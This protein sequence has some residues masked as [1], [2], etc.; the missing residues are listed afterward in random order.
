[1]DALD[2]LIE[3]GSIEPQL[4]MKI[5]RHFDKSITQILHYKA[6]GVMTFKGCLDTYNLCDEVWTFVM[7]DVTCKMNDET[8]TADRLKIVSC[9]NKKG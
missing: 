9:S 4:A 8:V 2:D 6:E 1:M 5:L 7:K 3:Q